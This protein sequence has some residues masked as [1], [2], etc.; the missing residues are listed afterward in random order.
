[1]KVKLKDERSDLPKVIEE[2][3]EV[4]LGLQSIRLCSRLFHSP[5]LGHPHPDRHE[6]PC[7]FC[8]S[9]I[10]AKGHLNERVTLRNDRRREIQRGIQENKT[11]Q[12]INCL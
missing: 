12:R 8:K 9:R 5:P 11:V 3:G 6:E 7:H 1:M 2:H 10:K 4:H